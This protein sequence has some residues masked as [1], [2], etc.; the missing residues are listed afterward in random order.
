MWVHVPASYALVCR[1]VY[2]FNLPDLFTNSHNLMAGQPTPPNV[3]PPRNEALLRACY[4]LVSLNKALS[5]P[6]VWCGYVRGIGWPAIRTVLQSFTFSTWI[7]TIIHFFATAWRKT[8]A[9]RYTWRLGN[10]WKNP[11]LDIPWDPGSCIFACQNK[12]FNQIVAFGWLVV[13]LDCGFFQWLISYLHVFSCIGWTIHVW[14]NDVETS[15]I[16][17]ITIVLSPFQKWYLHKSWNPS[18]ICLLF[19]EKTLPISPPIRTLQV[20]AILLVSLQ[21]V[22]NVRR[23][24]RGEVSCP[25]MRCAIY[26]L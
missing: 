18:K 26:L 11:W 14:P 15:R 3:P 8:P 6:Y 25:Y 23:H 19:W 10:W 7:S 17:W 20:A 5:N 16:G 1:S 21:P 22:R 9:S 13:I 24:G 4:W 12:L 2:T